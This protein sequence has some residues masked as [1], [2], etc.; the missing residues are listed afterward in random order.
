M[1]RHREIR[2]MN[3]TA[4]RN[5]DGL[6]DSDYDDGDGYGNMSLEDQ[7]QLDTALA[8][9]L[10]SLEGKD[11]DLINP[12]EIRRYLWDQW[13]D[14]DATL[15]WVRSEQNKRKVKRDEETPSSSTQTPAKPLS[16]LAQLAANRSSPSSSPGSKP[17]L[18]S[19]ADSGAKPRGT[20]RSDVAPPKPSLASLAS[21]ASNTPKA[22]LESLA[23][24]KSTTAAN[25]NPKPS[26]ASLATNR[27][28]AAKSSLASLAPSTSGSPSGT[29]SVAATSTATMN[30]PSLASLAA[31][32][33]T[34][35]A[36]SSGTGSK[37]ASLAQNTTSKPQSP[38]VSSVPNSATP[39][40]A[41]PL[42]KLALKAQ[43]AKGD[44]S[45][46]PSRATTS[47]AI[48][49]D[50][51]RSSPTTQAAMDV[52]SGQEI[53]EDDPLFGTL[54]NS[55]HA[56]TPG[57]V[58]SVWVKPEPTAFGSLLLISA[59]STFTGVSSMASNIG[60]GDLSLDEKR[61]RIPRAAVA[62]GFDT[63]SPDDLVLSKREGTRLAA[64]ARAS[65]EQKAA[66][67][68]QQQQKSV[69]GSAT[70]KK[71]IGIS[72][73]VLSGRNTPTSTPKKGIPG[74]PPPAASSSPSK[75]KKPSAPPNAAGPS[76]PPQ[77]YQP[78][79]QADMAGLN[80]QE[81]SEPMAEEVT[82]PP[83]KMALSREKVVEEA[84]K[85][86]E[87]KTGEGKKGLSLVII[88]HVDAGKSTLM[89]RLTYE[90]GQ[91]EEKKRRENERESNKAG[92][93]SFMWAW[94]MDALG[95]ERDRGVTI[96]INQSTLNLPNTSLTI[97]DAPG[98]R[99]FVPNMI[100]G[101]SQADAA[102]LVVDATTGEFEAGF[103]GGGQSREHVLLVRSLGVGTI[104]VAVNKLDMVNYSQAR[105]EEI[106][107]TL[108]PF[109]VQSG[110]SPSKTTFVP[111]AGMAGVNLVEKDTEGSD[112]LRKWWK[113]QTLVDALDSLQPPGR[114][115]E[116]PLRFPISNV[117]KGGGTGTMA[118]GTGVSGR[119]ASGV[120]QVGEKLRIL[121]GDETA[122]VRTVEFED[123][124]VPWAA[125][126]SN[127]T[128]Y[129]SNVDPVNL[130]I[131]SVL[132]P[133]TDVVP[134]ASS[135]IAQVIVFDI[136]VPITSGA[137]VEL[138]HH[139]RDTPASI[140]KLLATLD[141]NTGNVIK[142]SPRVLTKNTSAKIQLS[143][144]GGTL[145]APSSKAV[146]IP[147]E[148]F[149]SNKEMG[150]I[151]LRRGGETI[152]AGTLAYYRQINVH[153]ARGAK[154]VVAKRVNFP[155]RRSS[156]FEMNRRTSSQAL[157]PS[158]MRERRL[159]TCY[160]Q[161]ISRRKLWSFSATTM[162]PS[163]YIISAVCGIPLIYL[164]LT[165]WI[166]PKPLP[167]I[168]H[169]AITSF[170]GDIP[171]M[172]RDIR[173]EGT[174]FDGK[175]F[176]AEAFQTGAP[177]W[178]M[179]IGPSTKMVAIA[180]AQ[181]IE[182]FL[183]KATRSRAVDQRFDIML[184]AFSGTIPYG[185]V[186]L[187][188]NDMWRKHR[189]ITSPLM[190]SKYLKSMTPAI[191]N[192]A[193]SLVKLWESKIRKVAS[194]GATCFSC[195]DDFEYIALDAITS[196]TL[197]ESLGAVAYARSVIDASDP[198]VDSFGG[199]KFQL[200]TLPLHTSVRYLLQC[201]GN[202]TSLPP[203]ISY[204]VQQVRGWTPKFRAHYKLVVNH[205]FDRVSKV[206]QA[207]KEARDLGEEYHGS[208]LIGMIAEREGLAGQESLSEWELRDEVLTYILHYCKFFEMG[209][210]NAAF[211]MKFLTENPNVQQELH[212]ELLSALEDAPQD[213]PLTFDDLMSPDKTPYLEA[214][215]AEILRRGS[216]A[217]GSSK[218]GA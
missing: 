14:T 48:L 118:S 95:E 205:I 7:E 106:C 75:T 67:L 142:A 186:S 50:R 191:A 77:Q 196:I 122:I 119:L 136:Q 199:I 135:F 23:A 140:S 179:F 198:D 178:Q 172:A 9:V 39:G 2:N 154:L 107:S 216:V 101:A 194:K 105:Y 124:S 160:V 158:R 133:P 141:R 213:R 121:P 112:E 62:F 80:L 69:P 207:V 70:P 81:E 166:R 10:S 156:A 91:M 202:A 167:G 170:W 46:P 145:S 115:I 189:R 38:S 109:L 144:R 55:T 117:F 35:S 78:Q 21:K 61:L 49:P 143:L 32:R 134:L 36:A 104:V 108:K 137:S 204:V 56:T 125:A 98:H 180:D 111:V 182:D 37:L 218:Q 129:L 123:N 210:S 8:Q 20:P 159:G 15:K 40:G 93:G 201:I 183:N 85:A 97:L 103:A 187:K 161:F 42:S 217:A 59:P 13:F 193:R 30:K 27:P 127:V 82:L 214:V 41:K 33:S 57:N 76:R 44:S 192:N 5:E 174:I 138:F 155:P 169:F 74:A 88:G 132:C 139:S 54:P 4:A 165:K 12:G 146:S 66:K 197:G 53:L 100:S 26:L 68:Q 16:R 176:M 84:K 43:M 147:I 209:L 22:S 51:D 47:A 11:Y 25:P 200:P 94:E 72:T 164:A 211:S 208:C 45:G 19:L 110:F 6:D 86:I 206:R 126:G 83:P 130:N 58:V 168:P 195:E 181:E 71:S 149:A 131:G 190:S 52:D 120:V 171:R 17:K 87:W 152:A 188:T 157:R 63:P 34:G 28:T 177:I 3:I 203:A 175:G 60:I 96:D 18:A 163:P 29:A 99:D 90:L 114:P 64:G 215:V 148:T 89:G 1:S 24:T 162:S 65:G 212:D 102:L 185:M 92:K 153:R 173:T 31:S 184:T 151:L 116:A 113:G 73:P 128:L 79:L 150:R